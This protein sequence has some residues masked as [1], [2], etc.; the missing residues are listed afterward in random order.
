MIR[1]GRARYILY[2]GVLGWG[3]LTATLFTAWNLYT[4]KGLGAAEMIIPFVVFPLGG[5][6]WGAAM[7]SVMKK[8][9]ER[10]SATDAK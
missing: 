5:L 10:G 3:L 7:W 1:L 9:R 2:F 6:L 4:K 8:Q